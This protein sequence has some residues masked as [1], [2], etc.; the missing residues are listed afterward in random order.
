MTYEPYCMFS[1]YS[2]FNANDENQYET[3]NINYNSNSY[4]ISKEPM[5]ISIDSNTKPIH[6]SKHIPHYLRPKHIVEKRNRRE[7]KRVHNVNQA[8]LILQALLPF[9]INNNKN[10]LNSTRISK[11]CTLRKAIDYIEA[12]QNILNEIN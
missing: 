3:S 9:N 2:S 12:L 11:V 7:R 5:T 4:S 10:Q 6:R 8:F 1:Y